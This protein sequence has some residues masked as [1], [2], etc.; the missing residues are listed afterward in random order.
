MKY[1]YISVFLIAALSFSC[2]SQI[3]GVLKKDGSVIVTVE[4][5]AL[6][7]SMTAL[8]GS[9][10]QTGGMLDA[11]SIEKSITGAPGVKSASLKN[12]TPESVIG[13]IDISHI[14]DFLAIPGV[15]SHNFIV[16]EQ[17]GNAGK[18]SITVD[19]ASAPSM[20][21]LLSPEL[22][23]YLSLLMSPAVS[24]NNQYIV[25]KTAYLAELK[26]FYKAVYSGKSKREERDVLINNFITELQNAHI[27]LSIDFPQNINSV[28]GGTFS[29][30]RAEF[31]IPVLDLL[32][33]ETPLNYEIIW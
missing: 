15:R 7:S 11:K 17:N 5:T 30:K 27:R 20:V 28:R 14:N 13:N 16:Y 12:I 26:A 2:A 1:L 3:N 4:K 9:A 19:R 33:L 6:I 18:L 31:D 21:K 10:L 8:T 24:K 23:A 25:D 29:G 22:E 32:A